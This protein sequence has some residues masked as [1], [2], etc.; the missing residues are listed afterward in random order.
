MDKWRENLDRPNK[1]RVGSESE[2]S[3]RNCST[4]LTAPRIL[5]PL[6][7][8]SM[9]AGSSVAGKY[10]ADAPSEDA[11]ALVDKLGPDFG[12]LKARV[13][14]LSGAALVDEV[15]AFQ[16]FLDAKG[17]PP[18][19]A[20]AAADAAADATAADAFVGG[21]APWAPEASEPMWSIFKALEQRGVQ[22]EGC[23]TKWDDCHAAA[24]DACEANDGGASALALAAQWNLV[25][26][27]HYA[28][29]SILAIWQATDEAK[30]DVARLEKLLAT[31]KAA[32]EQYATKDAVAAKQQKVAAAEAEFDKWSKGK[33]FPD[34]KTEDDIWAEFVTQSCGGDD[35]KR[36][37]IGIEVDW[38]RLEKAA[39]A[40]RALL[41]FCESGGE[42][43]KEYASLAN[44]RRSFTTNW[45]PKAKALVG[46][47]LFNKGKGGRASGAV[48]QLT[49]VVDPRTVKVRV[50]GGAKGVAPE[51][52]A[53]GA[54][55][56]A[57]DVNKAVFLLDLLH[58]APLETHLNEYSD[59][60]DAITDGIVTGG[61]ALFHGLPKD[62][63]HECEMELLEG[64][65]VQSLDADGN[66]VYG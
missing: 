39:A 58:P 48:Y 15:R 63:R 37:S 64:K 20:A 66:P 12:S 27:V 6:K 53:L 60:I 50:L 14:D 9:G 17:P 8:G 47:Y 21:E 31:F 59:A 33:N 26:G 28:P 19:A 57:V 23:E 13:A 36:T 22:L 5:N 62:I 55:P 34:D 30:R 38:A 10:T 54:D 40:P 43:P 32:P 11:R 46:G 24:Q 49:G 25:P 3:Q 1:T 65:T 44:S 16:S 41:A 2:K 51:V 18:A 35:P 29:E 61:G 56:N 7:L 45:K 4:V 52:K 42:L